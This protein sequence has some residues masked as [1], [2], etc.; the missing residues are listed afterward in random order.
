MCE[1]KQN[2][3]VSEDFQQKKGSTSDAK[4]FHQWRNLRKTILLPVWASSSS[5]RWWAAGIFSVEANWRFTDRQFDGTYLFIKWFISWSKTIYVRISC[6]SSQVNDKVQVVSFYLVPRSRFGGS[7][8][9]KQGRGRGRERRKR[10]LLSLPPPP[11]FVLEPPKRDLGTRP[12][13]FVSC[14]DKWMGYAYGVPVSW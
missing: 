11:F 4:K 1:N 5:E 12:V 9:K 3:S 2:P 13:S 6:W 8:T 7:R 14:K 10:F